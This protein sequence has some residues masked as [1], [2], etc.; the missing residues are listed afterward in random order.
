[1]LGGF[2]YCKKENS[3]ETASWFAWDFVFND[4]TKARS[5]LHMYTRTYTSPTYNKKIKH[6]S[7]FNSQ[8]GV[9]QNLIYLVSQK[10]CFTREFYDLG[11]LAIFFF[12]FT[13]CLTNEYIYV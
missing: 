12:A 10:S 8:S 1:M 11:S 9:V 2:Y 4:G 13:E 6:N 3:Y 7:T 5:S